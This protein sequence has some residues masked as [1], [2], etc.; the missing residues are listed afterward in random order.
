MPVRFSRGLLMLLVVC[1]SS[2]MPSCLMRPA[3]AQQ[4]PPKERSPH[5]VRLGKFEVLAA[6]TYAKSLRDGLP[7]RE[8]KERGIV[9]AVMGARSRGIRRGGRT[10]PA[11]SSTA[12][13]TP[14]A[15][16]KTLTAETYDEQVKNKLQPFHDSV[17][18]P[19]LKKLVAARLSYEQ[20][21]KVLEDSS[22]HRRQ[23]HRG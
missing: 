7:D 17:F 18:L 4:V 14:G 23:D 2:L 13:Q 20:V 22:G 10:Q 1:P 5:D 21:K 3:Q 19:T 12:R 6:Y 8:A 15:K 16:K 9:A 11:D